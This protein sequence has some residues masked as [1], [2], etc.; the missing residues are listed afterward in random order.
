MLSLLAAAAASAVPA[1]ILHYVRTNR[2]GSEPEH[3]VMTRPTRSTVAVY[4]YVSRCTSAAL[5]TAAFD[6]ASGEV[7][8]LDAGKVGRQGEQVKFGRIDFDPAS[9]ILSARIDTP[10]GML[11]D[12]MRVPD[13]PWHLFDYDLATLNA[14]VQSVRPRRDFSFGLPLVWPGP[15]RFLRYP[16]RIEARFMG[17]DQHERRQAVRFDLS[18]AGA[19]PASGRLLLDA[20]DGHILLAELSIP[21]HDNYRDFRLTLRKIDKGGTKAWAKLLRRHYA[22]CRAGG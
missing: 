10:G 1:P 16:G 15:T 19:Q 7:A 5:V 3:I 14:E 6:P 9:R 12:A 18:L 13:R 2:D 8:S 22:G 11:A 4:K 17:Y 20:A 21:N